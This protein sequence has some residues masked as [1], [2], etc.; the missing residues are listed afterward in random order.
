[1][2][3]STASQHGVGQYGPSPDQ[4]YVASLQGKQV[5]SLEEQGPALAAAASLH[6]PVPPEIGH[7]LLDRQS[8]VYGLD[9]RRP[10]LLALHSAALLLEG[11]GGPARRTG[12]VA[13]G[14]LTALGV[15]VGVP[16]KVIGEGLQEKHPL[17]S[18]LFRGIENGAG[19]VALGGQG[20]SRVGLGDIRQATDRL[21]TV[22]YGERV[23]PDDKQRAA[24]LRGMLLGR[25]ARISPPE[26]I[27]DEALVQMAAQYMHAYR[28]SN[29]AG[30]VGA[31]SLALGRAN[32]Y[33]SDRGIEDTARMLARKRR[34][35]TPFDDHT[36]AVNWS[37]A[38]QI[39]EV[40]RA[41]L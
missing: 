35:G 30:R 18:S 14:T 24:A 17:F 23:T 21:L 34:S 5:A 1:M 9:S 41:S 37:L 11:Y 8:V 32:L 10:S 29:V 31:M 20:I 40:A 36:S 38:G 6:I 33:L 22:R 25:L 26:A 39:R 12:K 27:P 7:Q 16:A 2:A 13:G 3:V 19:A 15:V 4:L 28:R